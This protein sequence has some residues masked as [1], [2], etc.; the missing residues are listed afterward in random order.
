MH[1]K[2]KRIGG[3]VL[4]NKIDN[5]Y[6]ERIKFFEESY[7]YQP[8]NK[9]YTVKF[10]TNEIENN[11]DN[12]LNELYP[13]K[14]I[15]KRNPDIALRYGRKRYE[16]DNKNKTFYMVMLDIWIQC[17][18]VYM[19]RYMLLKTEKVYV[20]GGLFTSKLTKYKRQYN[21]DMKSDDVPYG[22]L[23]HDTNTFVKELN[24]LQEDFLSLFNPIDPGYIYLINLKK[25][26][27]INH[28]YY[29]IKQHINEIRELQSPIL[30]NT[31][32]GVAKLKFECFK[33]YFA[34]L[35]FKKILEMKIA[36]KQIKTEGIQGDSSKL[37][38]FVSEYVKNF[39]SDSKISNYK[40]YIT[41]L[42]N[43]NMEIIAHKKNILEQLGEVTERFQ[44]VDDENNKNRLTICSLTA[45]NN[46][47]R[48]IYENNKN[49]NRELLDMIALT[50]KEIESSHNQIIDLEC[51][52]KEFRKRCDVLESE[53][54]SLYSRIDELTKINQQFEKD[55]E[56]IYKLYP[57]SAPPMPDGFPNHYKSL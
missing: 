17:L 29:I 52:N 4:L 1:S 11:L 44:K 16:D 35:R 32:D 56:P 9:H 46:E 34:F 55:F 57:P 47:L 22:I 53:K 31:I 48:K 5:E 30:L 13:K 10:L 2:K 36:I 50:N 51:S 54:R 23:Y 3:D 42:E 43:Q 37:I 24:K 41:S 6:N 27:D 45:E 49:N 33:L 25:V 8:I 38:I 18:R 21:K 26:F 40:N 14:N 39:L 7:K 28:I 15:S 20:G 12:F 19:L